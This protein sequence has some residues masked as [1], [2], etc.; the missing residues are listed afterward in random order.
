MKRVQSAGVDGGGSTD[1]V[2]HRVAESP[3]IVLPLTPTPAL[4]EAAFCRAGRRDAPGSTHALD[5][6]ICATHRLRVS[7]PAGQANLQ[8]EAPDSPQ[9]AFCC[10]RRIAE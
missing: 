9:E 5:S 7:A 3:G 2:T 4:T 1:G 6:N 8:A 10:C